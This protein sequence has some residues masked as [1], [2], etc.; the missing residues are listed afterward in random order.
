MLAPAIERARAANAMG[1]WVWFEMVLAEI[2][3]D[4]GRGREAIRRFTAVAAAA[5][6]AGQE[7]VLVWAHV[8]VAQGHV[9][10][11]DCV[12]ATS[13][14]QRA[15]DV[16]DSPVATSVMTRERARAGLFACRGDLAAARALI[17]EVIELAQRDEVF[18]FELGALHDLVRFGAAGEAAGRLTELAG[19]INGPL[20]DAHCRHALAA[21]AGDARL[22]DD[23]VDRYERIDALGHA[24]EVAAEQAEV[25]RARGETRLATAARHRSA[26]LAAQA[27]GIHTPALARGAGVEPLTAREREVAL[28][29][30]GGSTSREIGTRLY[31]STRTVDTHLARVYRKLGI[32]TRG[33]LRS[34]LGISRG[35]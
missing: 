32:T 31:L 11:G 24:A 9:L 25:H 18:L 5:P 33:E 6:S 28:L 7:A 26:E 27:G 20:M 15:D 13:A 2:A 22:L 23:V 29:A 19:Q 3:R 34:A 4:T 12:A 30:A 16:G 8:G 21:A 1:A 35:T 17:R 10:L 14:M